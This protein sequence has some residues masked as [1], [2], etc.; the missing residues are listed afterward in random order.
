[1]IVVCEMHAFL[2]GGSG[3]IAPP[4][5]RKILKLYTSSDAIWDKICKHFDD[6]YLCP[7]TCK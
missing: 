2:L 1:M 3:G 7:V 4:P 6:T 5:T